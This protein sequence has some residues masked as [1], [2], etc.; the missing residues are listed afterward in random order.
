MALFCCLHPVSCFQSESPDP[1]GPAL[2]AGFRRSV[3]FGLTGPSR[4]RGRRGDASGHGPRGG[5]A[6]R[7]PNRRVL[8]SLR[9]A[10]GPAGEVKTLGYSLAPQY[11]SV[12]G[13]NP[14]LTGYEASN[15]V[16]VTVDQLA[17]LGKVIDA[18]TGTGANHIR[19][20]SF[21]LRDD[22]TVRAEALRQAAVKARSNAEVLA[23]ALG[24]QVVGLLQAEPTEV[25]VRPLFK[26][27]QTMAA[28]L[29][30][31]E[32]PIEAGNLEVRATVTVMLEVR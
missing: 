11:E 26:S 3:R 16:L 7:F 12:N 30:R 6:K 21:T 28:G 25:P 8:T 20:I 31:I 32:T 2:C 24:V 17:L 4:S 9:P 22:S 15:T 23:K 27:A 19:G 5:L 14:H 29:P 13:R 1:A 10:L 18:A